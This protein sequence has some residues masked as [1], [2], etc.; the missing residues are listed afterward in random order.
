[1]GNDYVFAEDNSGVCV[2][3]LYYHVA[4]TGR[5]V[6]DRFIPIVEGVCDVVI[7]SKI[8]GDFVT[9]INI[10]AFEDCTNLKSITIPDS[11]TS[12]GGGA[13]LNCTSLIS[14]A[15]SD[16]VTTIDC[17]AFYGCS[18]LK[19]FK[20]RYFKATDAFMCCKGFKYELNKT[21]IEE[22]A[23]L[24]GRGFH[25]CKSPLDVFNYY[26]GDIGRDVRLFEVKLSNVSRQKRRGDSKRVGKKIKFIR[27]LT[28]SDL[29]RLAS[30][31]EV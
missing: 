2:G 13:F 22:K 18:N 5:A 30:G 12:I 19:T 6:I 8:N 1:M 28:I 4:H 3:K 29:A 17:G 23:D 26:S 16:S 21:F 15:I 11:V 7:P 31:E 27:E 24:C 9:N 10:Y 14:I 20:N 25:A